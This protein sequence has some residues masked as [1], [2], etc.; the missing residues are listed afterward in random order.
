M[1]IYTSMGT[2]SSSFQPSKSSTS[3]MIITSG[4]AIL[5]LLISGV[6]IFAM[7]KKGR[8]FL[9]N[10]RY[11][12]PKG[13]LAGKGLKIYVRDGCF[14]C[15]KIKKDIKMSKNAE[16][17]T[18]VNIKDPAFSESQAKKEGYKG[19]IPFIVDKNGNYAEGYES[20][21]KLLA[22][23]NEP[24]EPMTEPLKLDFPFNWESVTMVHRKGCGFGNRTIDMIKKAG[25]QDKIEII[26]PTT[27]KG[28]HIMQTT[29]AR[30]VPVIY[31][32]EN[33]S[34]SV[35]M[36]PS[37][38]ELAE[39][40]SKPPE[41][42]PTSPPPSGVKIAGNA[43]LLGTCEVE[44]FGRD[45]CG[46]TI[47]AKQLLEGNDEPYRFRDTSGE[48]REEFSK[49]GVNGVPHFV[50]KKT[51]KSHTGY[52]SSV[53]ALATA[54]ECPAPSP[55]ETKENTEEEK[56]AEGSA[57]APQ[58]T[59]WAEGVKILFKPDCPYCRK[60]ADLL[61]QDNIWSK[62]KPIDPNTPEGNTL[63]DELASTGAVPHFLNPKTNKT[64]LGLPRDVEMLKN[65]LI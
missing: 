51:G 46:F 54:L 30:G 61:A 20:M 7:S 56:A 12:G 45:S 34:Y 42:P 44:L 17:V 49:M 14:F 1:I 62:M 27:E 29:Q 33:K 48:G 38:K 41:T 18:I 57:P 10:F 58:D 53:Q 43:K 9:T 19:A 36:P 39:K 37:M 4:I 26:Q 8:E 11:S 31:N 25:L 35:G 64:F 47:K 28:R 59:S 40:L 22:A 23:L 15:D 5:I 60:T 3:S 32:N 52:P 13:H 65:A 24:K 63:I 2:I 6:L 16:H 21:E 55:P 50:S